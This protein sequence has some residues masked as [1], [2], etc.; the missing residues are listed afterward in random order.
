MK[1][2]LVDDEPSLLE[3]AKV[4][5]GME[6]QDIRVETCDSG[7]EALELLENGEF[8]AVIS[9]FQMPGMDGLELLKMI[10]HEI[11]T[12]IPFIIFTGRGREE[13]AVEALN[14]GADRYIQKGGDPKVLYGVLVQAIKQEVLRYRNQEALKR[15]E[16]EKR[17]ILEN[18]AEHVIYH[19]M[20]HQVLWANKAAA[21]SVGKNHWELVGKKC[22][23][24]WGDAKGPCIDCPVT[25]AIESGD[26][27]RGEVQSPDGRYWWITASPEINEDGDI[28]RVVEISMDI[29]DRKGAEALAQELQSLRTAVRDINQL[30]VKEDGLQNILRKACHILNEVRP[31]MAVTIAMRS[32]G[33]KITPVAQNVS[34]EDV[35]LDGQKAISKEIEDII[36]DGT[37]KIVEDVD[38]EWG[39]C[40]ICGIKE[41]HQAIIVPMLKEYKLNGVMGACVPLD[42]DITQE[43]R[44]LLD[45]VCGDLAFA[46]DKIMAEKALRESE[47]RYRNLVER[48]ND[49]VV[50]IQD[51]KIVYSNPKVEEM[52]GYSTEEL[53]GTSF[54]D[55]VA[56]EELPKLS[57][58]YQDRMK[59]KIV[60]SVYETVLIKK[61]GTPFPVE[62]NASIMLQ[63]NIPSDIVLIRDISMRKKM[64]MELRER[65]KRARKQRSAVGRLVI[66]DTLVRGDQDRALKT[67]TKVLSETINV[68]RASVWQL[69]E[70]GQELRCLN[71]YE[72]HR[73]EHSSGT[74]LR[75]NDFP[76]YFHAM[77]K[78]SRIYAEDAVM[79]PRTMELSENYLKPL[80]IT[81]MMDA[82]IVMEGE[83][84][85]VVCCEH[86]G[87]KRRWYP[88]EES[89]LSTVATMIAQLFADIRRRRAEEELRATKERYQ[90]WIE[91]N[92]VGVGITDLD[93]NII[94]A[95][96]RFAD[97][98]GYHREEFT[99][100]NLA[101]LSS[102][103]D[104][105]DMKEKTK[106]RL[107]DMSEIY[108]TRLKKK[109]GSIIDVMVGTTPHKT[110]EG[111]IIGTVGF[112]QDITE[113]KRA[114]EELRVYREELEEMVEKRTAEL[115]QSEDYNRSLLELI[116]DIMIRASREGE[117]LDIIT[118][119]EDKL[120]MPREEVLGKRISDLFP[121]P[122]AALIMEGIEECIESKTLQVVEYQIPIVSG[123][124]LW[125]EARIVPSGKQEIFALIR[126]VTKSKDAERVLNEKN[127]EME[128]FVY[129]VTHDLRAPLRAIQGFG[130]IL[131]DESTVDQESIELV[132]RMVLAAER[133]DTLIQDLLAY[134][135][136]SST[137]FKLKICD[138]NNVLKAVRERLEEDIIES[139]ARINIEG[140]PPSVMGTE[141][142]LE[143]IIS[144]LVSNA[145]KFV[146]EDRSP[147]IDISWEFDG[148]YVYIYLRDNGIGIKEEDWEQIFH[149]FN[150]LH[151]IESYPGTGVGLAIVKKGVEKLGGSCG[152]D[153]V[154]GE[155]STFHI[156]LKKGAGIENDQ[157]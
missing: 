37:M 87:K 131:L 99:G 20:D 67:I 154:P 21:D 47:E 146:P 72:S 86:I 12:N 148:N 4:F 139:E 102:Q 112:I 152:V 16:N 133:M 71:L 109:D 137:E 118:K 26:T 119:D 74:V 5:I 39:E 104:F 46:R 76:S 80:G 116:P 141:T 79:D 50:V 28:E 122:E 18:T 59:G 92:I 54:L 24:I 149:I 17:R 11:K 101:N 135:R 153:S 147:R 125:F 9:D 81:S 143:Q 6:D 29:T 68:A 111:E 155:G 7:V 130:S 63:K 157:R 96:E 151:G 103:E 95:N 19:G 114:E 138:L 2:I 127:Q 69:S 129:S 88:D 84:V 8:H 128:A 93:E 89:F 40:P 106:N 78:E 105:R 30:I 124:K 150:R 33:G 22:Y 43:E 113:R 85:G 53:K 70:D 75:T 55:H 27:H 14:L 31:Y 156:K 91:H 77:K 61:N 1:I 134:S 51:W 73:D 140:S 142:L 120:I 35:F 49:G 58:Y 3:Q 132:S 94:F 48:A 115:K 32:E 52:S 56:P 98:L 66:E 41:N 117:Y 23:K 10:R 110:D 45:E 62:L 108:E 60:P 13:V 126:D 97:M 15:S 83:Q 64:E 100:M 145:I 38:Q 82:G 36:S 123:R 65:E 25:K 34:G 42:M 107:R 44:E 57:R 136:I 90:T 121:E 144:N